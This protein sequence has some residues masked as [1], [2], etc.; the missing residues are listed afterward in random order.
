[1][2][3]LTECRSVVTGRILKVR[4]L[5]LYLIML[6]DCHGDFDSEKLT[7]IITKKNMYCE[8]NR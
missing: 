6:L 8:S 3:K 2:E 4:K 1:M 5:Q 7:S